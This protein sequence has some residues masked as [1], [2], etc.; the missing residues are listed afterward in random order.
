MDTLR[1]AENTIDYE[2]I[3]LSVLAIEINGRRI[4]DR[5][6]P[7]T[8]AAR[9]IYSHICLECFASTRG[10]LRSC[11]DADLEVRRDR[12]EVYWFL[13]NA[14]CNPAGVA[15]A[16]VWSFDRGEYEQQLTGTASQLP[17]L[18]ADEITELLQRNQPIPPNWGLYTTLD[19]PDDPQ[20][21]EFLAAVNAILSRGDFVISHAPREFPTI[22]VGLES[23]G[24][25]ECVVEVGRVANRCAL[26]FVEDPQF[27]LWV[28][29]DEVDRLMI[30]YLDGIH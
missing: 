14:N 20:G 27:P 15:P 7:F 17:P 28:T 6:A 18:A 3:P 21:R 5:A 2:G 29:S 19:L 9:V 23:A 16:Q 26:R 13:A 24:V 12:E 30:R 11:S 1:I 10:Q 8:A 4:T 25:P 22:R